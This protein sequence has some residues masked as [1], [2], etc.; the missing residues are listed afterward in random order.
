MLYILNVQVIYFTLNEEEGLDNYQRAKVTLNKYFKPQA[1]LQMFHMKAFVFV[2]RV[3]W[4]RK[5]SNSLRP[6]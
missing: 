3:N 1:S 2:K 4:T 6:D 5:P